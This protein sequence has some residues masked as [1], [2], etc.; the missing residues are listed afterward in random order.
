MWRILNYFEV[1]I[2]YSYFIENNLFCDPEF[3][4]INHQFYYLFFIYF[5]NL[6]ILFHTVKQDYPSI[7]IAEHTACTSSPSSSD[8]S[9]TAFQNRVTTSSPVLSKFQNEFDEKTP[10]KWSLNFVVLF[11]DF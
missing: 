1:S 10:E 7:A 8:F 11:A 3:G 2:V 5:W 4:F 9:F 6:F